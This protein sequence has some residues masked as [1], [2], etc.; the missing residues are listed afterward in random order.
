LVVGTSGQLARELRRSTPSS[1]ELVPA[2]KLDLADGAACREALERLGPR[3]VVTAGAFT[4]VDRAESER[5]QALAVNADGPETL[6]RWCQESRAALI[7]VSTDYVFDGSKASPYLPSDPPGPLNVYGETKLEG[8]R[9]VRAAL[10]RH[11]ILRTSWVFSAHGNNF[12][13]TMLRLAREREELKVVADQFGRPTFAGDLARAIWA[14]AAVLGHGE[15]PA[16][17]THHFASSGETSWCELARATVAEQARFTGKAPVV[18]AISAGDYPTP[19]RRP[20]NSR[21][22]TASFEHAFSFTP[23]PWQEGL[24]EVV[25]ELSAPS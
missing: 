11:V 5:A 6:A 9:R 16:W 25:S 18:T 23:P 20:V 7:H 14:V 19:A 3:L 24:R 8:E 10:A 4:A 21:L 13:K 15:A 2:E 12:V 17:G 1:V 22:D